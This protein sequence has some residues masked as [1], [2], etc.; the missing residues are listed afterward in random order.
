MAYDGVECHVLEILEREKKFVQN[1][2]PTPDRPMP[3]IMSV[4]KS[5]KGGGLVSHERNTAEKLRSQTSTNDRAWCAA[6]LDLRVRPKPLRSGKSILDAAASVH[7]VRIVSLCSSGNVLPKI[8]GSYVPYHEAARSTF[9]T[10]CLVNHVR[11]VFHTA[12]GRR[13]LAGME[14]PEYI[15]PVPRYDI[16]R[17]NYIF[18][19]HLRG[20]SVPS[21]EG[22]QALKTWECSQTRAA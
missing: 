9:R 5:S 19:R 12:S 21:Y 16:S 20:Y 11:L 17:R 1:A 18:P 2:A 3:P 7:R 13:D 22:K 10:G 8:Y 4:P 6:W 14:N 15:K